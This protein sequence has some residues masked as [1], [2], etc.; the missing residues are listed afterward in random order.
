M[1]SL[2]YLTIEETF[3]LS[4]AILDGDIEAIK[5]ELGD[6]LFHILL[7][8]RITS[9]KHEL[10]VTQVIESLCTKLVHRH[11]HVYAGERVNGLQEVQ[12]NW[13]VLKLKEGKKNPSVLGGVPRTLPSLVKA[14]RVQEKV[15]RVGFTGWTDEATG[16]MIQQKLQTLVH[17]CKRNAP[18]TQVLENQFGDILFALIYYAKLCQVNAETALEKTT[19]AFIKDFQLV[20]RQAAERG[21]KI[22]QLSAEELAGRWADDAKQ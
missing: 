1:E 3:E 16:E 8:V 22:T 12:K 19:R 18:D 15:C 4:E 10:T 20:E 6:L 13:E 7:Y 9:E 11:P 17:Q 5:E 2:R 14:M 21:K